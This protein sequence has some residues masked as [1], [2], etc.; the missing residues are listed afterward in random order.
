MARELV[1]ITCPI[2]DCPWYERY[3]GQEHANDALV[4]HCKEKHNL[5][6]YLIRRFRRYWLADMRAYSGWTR[7][8]DE[9]DNILGLP[10]RDSGLRT[11]SQKLMEAY[12][13]IKQ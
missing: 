10:H 4:E 3:W 9:I 7:A 6:E 5:P 11:T 12:L 2:R 1:H 8:L 13:G